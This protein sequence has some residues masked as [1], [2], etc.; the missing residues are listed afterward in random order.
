M[1]DLSERQNNSSIESV[2]RTFEKQSAIGGL[3]LKPHSSWHY[4]GS[5]I[6]LSTCFDISIP[7][8]NVT[9]AVLIISLFLKVESFKLLRK[10]HIVALFSTEKYEGYKSQL[11]WPY[12]KFF[13]LMSLLLGPLNNFSQAYPIW[14]RHWKTGGLQSYLPAPHPYENVRHDSEIQKICLQRR[15]EHF[16]SVTDLPQPFFHPLENHELYVAKCWNAREFISYFKDHRIVGF[17]A[18]CADAESCNEKVFW[19]GNWYVKDCLSRLCMVHELHSSWKWLDCK[20]HVLP[21]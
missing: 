19:I 13:V 5:I 17:E 7:V 15:V 18:V 14:L 16:G 11:F 8:A 6:V 4:T 9:S 12:L 20:V 10:N 21:H 3:K 2:L 1:C